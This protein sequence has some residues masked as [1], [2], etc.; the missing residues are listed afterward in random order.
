MKAGY[1]IPLIFVLVVLLFSSCSKKN[2]EGKFVPK[3]AAIVIHINGASLSSKLPW[4]EVKKNELFQN[5][6][7]DT[8]IPQFVKKAFD[9]PENSGID[10]K[11]DLIFF[12]QKDS[13]GGYAAFT[14]TIKDAGKFKLFNLDVAKTGVE[15]EKDGIKYI[16]KSTMCVGWNKESFVYIVNTPQLNKTSYKGFS[17]DSGISINTRDVNAVC[18]TVFDLKENNSLAQNEKFTELVKKTGDVHLWMNSE[19]LSK[20]ALSGVALGMLNINKLY[21]GSITTATV[22]FENGKIL[23]DAKSYSGEELTAI[24]KKYGGR[25]VDESMIKRLPAKDMAAVFSMSFK[26][27][28]IKEFLKLLGVEGYAN[29]GLAFLGFTLDDFIKAN[30]GDIVIALSDFKTITDSALGGMTETTTELLKTEP[31]ILFATSISDKDAFTKLI[32]AG[33]RMGKDKME[34]MPSISFKSNGNYFAI[35]NSKENVD[36]FISGGSNN[37][38]DFVSKISGQPFGGYINLQYIL[39]AFEKE[40]AKDSAAKMAYDASLKFWDNV[41]IKGGDYNNGGITQT[42][43][44]NLMD[45]TTNSAKQLNSYMGL[46]AKLAKQEDEKRKVAESKFDETSYFNPPAVDLKPATKSHK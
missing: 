37:N 19:T 43:E 25:N 27:E 22:N 24:W 46:I 3:D 4:E 6:N 42:V 5:V 12:L 34:G 17:A 41:Y 38:F 28:G 21:E 26:P 1:Q 33:E 16:T 18:K 10:T 39:K 2:K 31:R 36:K 40:A 32:K 14:G 35:G 15:S 11:T 20:D 13:L 29:M 30:K 8:S 23:L 45:K 44:I 7:G 9:N